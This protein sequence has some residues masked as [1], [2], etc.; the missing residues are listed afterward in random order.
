M[1][2]NRI[3]HHMLDRLFASMV[4]SPALNCRPHNSRQRID[5][6]HLSRLKD[7]APEEALREL[8]GEKRRTSL[9]GTLSVPPGMASSF[10]RKPVADEEAEADAEGDAK[11]RD[12]RQQHALLSKL[13]VLGEDARIYQQDTGVH[14]L[15]IGY[16]ILSLPPGASGGSRR[17][18]APLA[19]IPVTLTVKVG[20]RPSVEI[21]CRGEGGDLV[22]ANET[23]MAWLERQTGKPAPSELFTDD[24]GTEPWREIE[25]LITLAAG[26]LEIEGI[27]AATLAD[28]DLFS[29]N[30]ASKAEDLG[31][32]ATILP[33]AVMG[34]FPLSNQ[35]LL[36][37]TQSM[38]EAD[39]IAGPIQPFV[40]AGV[41]LEQ[42]GS[43]S[44]E[45]E[46]V[47]AAAAEEIAC[48]PRVF[49]DERLI[50]PAD[51][52]QSRAVKYA[53]ES[54]G[55]VVHGPPGT[56]KSQT[57]TNV[58]GDHLARGQ[59]VLFV[60]DKRTALDVVKNRLDHL[61]LGSLCALIH[62]PQRDQRDLY[63][64]IRDQIET[65][66]EAKVPKG[67]T[68]KL[69]RLDEELQRIH[70]E[71][72]EV[73]CALMDTDEEGVSLHDLTGRWLAIR[74]Y[75]APEVAES[76]TL[77][78]LRR[79]SQNMEVI[80]SRAERIAYPTNRWSHCA[81]LTL[82]QFLA[83]PVEAMRRTI[84]SCAED[85]RGVDATGHE[86][87][88]PFNPE[89]A[90]DAQ[91]QRRLS[92]ADQ[93]EAVAAHVDHEVRKRC[94]HWS[95]DVAQRHHRALAELQPH[96]ERM[97]Q[98]PLDAELVMTVRQSIPVP[99]ALAR[100]IGTL[101]EYIDAC[102]KFFGFLSFGAKSRGKKV[103][104]E[105][106][107]Q[108]TLDEAKRLHQ[109]LDGLRA[110]LVL[111]DL[112]EQLIEQ[113]PS[114][115]LVDD[116]TLEPGLTQ[117]ESV[118]ALLA[119][120]EGRAEIRE[121]M[122]A[123]LT[124]EVDAAPLLD[125]LRRSPD[126][127]RGITQF[128][129]TMRAA[130]LYDTT[131]LDGALS[132]LREGKRA[133]ESMEALEQQFDS[134]EDVLRVRE[135][136]E[137]LPAGM[138]D[139]TRL[140]VSESMTPQEGSD[141][142]SKSV[143]F[144]EIRRRLDASPD[145]VR[146][147]AERLDNS[148]LRYRELESKKRELVRQVILHEWLA[149][150]KQRLL[151]GT[152]SRLNSLGAETR[153]RLTMRGR[154]AMRLRQVIL[155]GKQIED[156]DPLF[157]ICPVWMASPE[158]VAQVFDREPVFDVVI[159]DEASQCRLEEALPV[160]L[161]AK[162]V[163]IAGDPKQLP[164]TRFFEAAVSV[165]EDVEI[166]TDQDLFELQLG[167]IEDLL[168]AALNLEIQECYLDVHYRSRNAD[169][170]QFS[171]VQFYG[172]RLQAI[173]GHP[174]NIARFPP[175]TIHRADGVYENRT[176][177]DE[178]KQVV[179]L[180]DDLLRRA[181]PPSVGIASFNLTQR[182]LINE[183]LDERSEEDK[184]FAKRLAKARKR[185]GDGSFEGLFVKNLEN[186]QGD[187]R[188]HIIVSTTYGPAPNGKFYKRFGPLGRVGG[189]R[190]LNVLVTRAREELHLVTSIPREV[191][192][193]LPPVPAGQTPGGGWL[194]FRYLQFAEEL[195]VAYDENHRVLEQT[196]A[197]GAAHTLVRP[198]ES[199]S[200]FAAALGNHLADEH[201]MSN[202]V[203]WG[204][205]G[206]CIDV[207]LHH[208]RQLEN[209][210]VGVLC[211]S[212][213]FNKA[214]DPVEWDIFRTGI[215]EAVGWTTHRLWTPVFFRDPK[216]CVDRIQ[217]AS[218]ELRKLESEADG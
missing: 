164:P 218:E 187:E 35:G 137:S 199:P 75:A 117:H 61:G 53:R 171:N 118:L 27:D 96:V 159:F 29:L 180:V 85:A 99:P 19:F 6:S 128:D 48:Q 179:Q 133:S 201:R 147:D 58:I 145:L 65:L 38:I 42:S 56:G 3:L 165:S 54:A 189:G 34:L 126:R 217:R 114:G 87:I 119:L 130:E 169:L 66:A 62:D 166:E 11:I 104:R 108:T 208:P 60:C 43:P 26:Q 45:E 92:V 203:H 76:I 141:A 21:E 198:S 49:S 89:E 135:G 154:R 112:Y 2:D 196:E 153:R 33:S 131:W 134:L 5:L 12:Y 16:P 197:S 57:I 84:G 186:V 132:Q 149:K 64:A 51:P 102:S 144:H 94:V 152:G 207:A 47:A 195:A 72:T 100:Q 13:R 161:R 15:Y 156:G 181:D 213:R 1:P 125:G 178:A 212:S 9:K 20:H 205:D 8:L 14:A 200:S 106:G 210:T 151:V 101:N 110:R 170:I 30:A 191:Y 113:A 95:D 81:G 70:G 7:I 93:L 194:L 73:H 204:N 23:L 214:P 129:S 98:G 82:E 10:G 176:N 116:A 111:S 143:L 50:A 206:F 177:M 36:R 215:L 107:L 115:N 52:C 155:T 175:L 120:V 77:D 150:Q 138:V 88:P 121:P 25:E 97:K 4:N 22:V 39:T 90:L 127:A 209:M 136:I 59:R 188:D 192:A 190:R 78:V 140:L 67:A 109:F 63:R 123:A 174:S 69:E 32:K 40:E 158:T 74:T 139:A 168:A 41:S 148:M 211:D 71:L 46:A 24:D 167:E 146:I 193:S 86:N 83:R 172:N 183:L 157:D 28:P 79:E 184:G 173:P 162:R 122:I 68:K 105:F 202:D 80:F 91:C 37:D 103:L 182:D 44:A 18:L 17:I 163:V 55:L 124:G 31:E 142:I 185:V 216:G 160:L